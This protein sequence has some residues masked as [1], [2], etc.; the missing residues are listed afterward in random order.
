[1]PSF[2]TTNK[3]TIWVKSFSTNSTGRFGVRSV[4]HCLA[5]KLNR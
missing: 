3:Q 4:S 2:G 1:M 5:Q